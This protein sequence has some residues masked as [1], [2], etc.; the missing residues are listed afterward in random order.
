MHH[1]GLNASGV[2]DCDYFLNLGDQTKAAV[3]KAQGCRCRGMLGRLEQAAPAS[4]QMK[5]EEGLAFSQAH[6]NRVAVSAAMT[7]ESQEVQMS[8]DAHSASELG[9][10]LLTKQLAA[11]Q[12]G[13][14][15][16]VKLAVKQREAALELQLQALQ[17]TRHHPTH[18]F[19]ETANACSID[20]VVW[21]S[22]DHAMPVTLRTHPCKLAF[23]AQ[24]ELLQ[25]DRP[26]RQNARPARQET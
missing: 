12:E 19:A 25:R 10:Y 6:C 23:S 9:P 1:T 4:G 3:P 18:C 11:L 26:E 15:Q 21:D 8:G 16:P 17:C 20:V 14:F 13:D 22:V 7:P 2:V 5:I 24:L